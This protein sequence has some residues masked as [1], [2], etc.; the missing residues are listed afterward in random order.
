MSLFGGIADAVRSAF[1]G[2]SSSRSNSSS[3]PSSSPRPQSRSSNASNNYGGSGMPDDWGR[4]RGDSLAPRSSPR[5]AA[6]PNRPAARAAMTPTGAAVS[7]A[8]DSRLGRS[9]R[10]GNAAPEAAPRPRPSQVADSSTLTRAMRER[11]TGSNS[12]RGSVLS[13]LYKLPTDGGRAIQTLQ[14]FNGGNRGNGLML[15]R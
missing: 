4:D 9:E 6:N 1:G 7:S 12:M 15:G 10:A 2:G 8:G 3:A 11:A 13:S 5:P 14:S